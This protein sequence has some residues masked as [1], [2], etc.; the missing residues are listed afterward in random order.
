MQITHWK[1]L[2]SLAQ[3]VA[4]GRW[5]YASQAPY[6]SVRTGN[7]YLYILLDIFATEDPRFWAIGLSRC[8]S[9][10]T[11]KFEVGGAVYYGEVAARVFL[12][13]DGSTL[14]KTCS[15]KFRS[16]LYQD[17]LS[18]A[19]GAQWLRATVSRLGGDGLDVSAMMSA[20]PYTPME[21][22]FGEIRQ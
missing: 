17:R 16:M 7:E 9:K 18:L 19:E 21:G 15:S 1:M 11:F 13:H 6:P 5:A 8:P 4:E 14:F 3:E 20:I 22:I 10:G 12:D 2:E